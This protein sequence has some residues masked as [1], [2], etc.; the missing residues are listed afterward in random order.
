MKC[1][2]TSSQA[3]NN[4]IQLYKT[5]MA[6][7]KQKHLDAYFKDPLQNGERTK[8]LWPKN[9]VHSIASQSQA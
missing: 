9:T 4:F 5:A 6:C 1:V 2:F 8:S 3:C 7:T